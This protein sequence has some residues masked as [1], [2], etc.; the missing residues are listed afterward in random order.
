[1][2][3]LLRTAFWLT[4]VMLLMPSNSSAPSKPEAREV[5]AGDAVSAASATITDMRQFCSRQAEACTVGSQIIQQLGEA[6]RHG[7][8]VV[9]DLVNAQAKA[10]RTG[11]VGALGDVA[12]RSTAKLLRGT[13]TSDDIAPSWRGPAAAGP[14]ASRAAS[15]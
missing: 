14:P 3:F 11:S 7:A 4:V 8:R 13:L 15:E 5:R 12:G 9:H 2:M 1:M 6:A 10:E